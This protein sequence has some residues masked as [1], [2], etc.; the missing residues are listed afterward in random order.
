VF[1]DGKVYIGGGLEASVGSSFGDASYRIDIYSPN[2][3]SW[4]PSPINTSYFWFAMTTLNNQL[5]TAGGKDRS[6]KVTNKIFLLD[7]DHL[8]EYTRMITPRY[9]ST[10]AGHQGTLIITGGE[11]DQY[12]RLATTEMFNST[13]G[14]WYTTSY[15]PLPHYELHSVIVDYTLYLLGG[16]NKDGSWSQAVF[17]APLDTLSSHNLQWS[18]QQNTP[19]HRSAPVSMQGRHLLA[20]GGVKKK[21]GSGYVCSSDIHKFNEVSRIWEV[22]GQIPSARRAPAAVSVADNKIAVVGGW[23]DEGHYTNTVWIG[24]CEPQ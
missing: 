9:S 15:L 12:R 10:A 23:D 5:I 11:D 14:Q 24:S 21:T 3:N 17:A 4:S 1:C 20:V 19:C 16:V 8:K 22:I 13:T 2:N 6:D 7:S 18:S